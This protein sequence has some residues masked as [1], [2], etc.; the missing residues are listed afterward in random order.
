VPPKR[1]K[2][3]D[4]SPCAHREPIVSRAVCAV[5]GWMREIQKLIVWIGAPKCLAQQGIEVFPK[6]NFGVV[7]F[8]L[9]PFYYRTTKDAT[10]AECRESKKRGSRRTIVKLSSSCTIARSA[11]RRLVAADRRTSCS[12]TRPA[13]GRADPSRLRSSGSDFPARRRLQPSGVMLTERA[14]DTVHR[15]DFRDPAARVKNPVA[16]SRILAL[17]S[18]PSFITPIGK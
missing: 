8:G 10:I 13:C 9:T 11:P 18:L 6:F 5:F 16:R 2:D 1:D 4:L 3:G 7:L 12:N 14:S 15:G 17:I